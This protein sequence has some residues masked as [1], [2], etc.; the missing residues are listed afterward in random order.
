MPKITL[1]LISLLVAVSGRAGAEPMVSALES[2]EILERGDFRILHADEPEAASQVADV[3]ADLQV[4]FS[5]WLGDLG[6]EVQMPGAPL[7]VMLVSP[8]ELE[9][10]R[11]KFEMPEGSRG[12]YRKVENLAVFP[13]PEGE[14]SP[15]ARRIIRH[16][17]T[18]LLQFNLGLLDRS[19]VEPPLWLLEGMAVRF[20]I[21]S[22]GMC[23]DSVR[24]GEFLR[25][26]PQ[27]LDL[28]KLRRLVRS[29]AYW[30]HARDQVVAG[31]LI[32]WLELESPG[33]LKR[34]LKLCGRN[35][36]SVEWQDVFEARG[37][38]LTGRFEQALHAAV[39]AC[40]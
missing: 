18:H 14:L 9:L 22:A 27:P 17:G 5:Q 28:P 34:C 25:K 37:V 35:S 20:E 29:N 31:M 24:V 39:E 15:T 3:L 19:Q 21:A 33:V 30:E 11:Q 7:L 26:V 1:A 4:E 2:A 12:F 16:E 32:R 36:Q 6:I 8:A 13:L 10:L 38:R 40:R 23:A